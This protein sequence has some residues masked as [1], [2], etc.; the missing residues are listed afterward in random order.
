MVSTTNIIRLLLLFAPAALTGCFS[1]GREAPTEKH[2]VLGASE[3]P[4]AIMPS[5]RLSGLRIGLRQ[6]QLAEYLESPLL[7][8][9]HGLHRVHYSEF[10]R[11]GGTLSSGVNRAVADYLTA[12]ARLDAVDVAPWA[13]R[14]THDY[15][16]QIHLLHLEGL[17]P[18]EPTDL[19]GG[20]HVRASWEIISPQ[21]G[22]VLVRGTTDY[23]VDDWTVGDYAGLVARLDAGLLELSRDLVAALAALGASSGHDYDS[24]AERPAPLRQR[25][26]A[27]AS[28]AE[29]GG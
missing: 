10:N 15:L 18:D 13:S 23:K 3:M 20:A 14:T 28:R 26:A 8:V 22:A 25:H 1:L 2:F 21:D 4:D 5:D 17:A 9:R 11:W 16:I 6:L 27:P 24:G 19:E 7:V 29:R 12:L